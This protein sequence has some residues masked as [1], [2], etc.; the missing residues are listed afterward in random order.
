MLMKNQSTP[1][2]AALCLLFVSFSGIALG[3]TLQYWNPSGTGGDGIWGTGPGDKNWNLVPGALVGNTAWDDGIDDVAVFQDMIGGTVTVFDTVQTAGISQNGSNYTVNAGIIVLVPDS[4]SNAPF[5]HVQGGMLTMDAQL[6]GNAGLLKTGEGTLLLSAANPYTG[7]T[8]IQG[9][10]V[11]LTGSLA[12]SSLSI[13]SGASLLNQNGG[14]SSATSLTNVGSLTLNANDTITSYISNGGTLTNGPGTLFTTSAEINDGSTLAGLLNAST[15]TSNGEVVISGTATAGSTSIES[16][17]L[18]LSGTLASNSVGIANGALL[19]NQSGGLSSGAVIT[20]AG[21]LVMNEN[22]S[23]S[24]YIS[25]GGTLTN[26]PRT[27]FVSDSFLNQGSSVGGLL[28]TQ[29][30][31]SNG[32]VLIN[33]TTTISNTAAVQSGTF[34]LTGTLS[35]PTLNIAAGATMIQNGTMGPGTPSLATTVLTNE[36]SLII[37]KSA[38]LKTYTSNG[39]LLDIQNDRMITQNVFLNDGSVTKGGSFSADLLTTTGAVRIENSALGAQAVVASGVLDLVGSIG[40]NDVQ[41]ASGA[42]LLNQNGGL[43]NTATVTNAGSLALFNSDQIATY[44]SNGGLLANSPGTLFSTSAILN[45]G[46]TVAGLLDT[47]TLASNGVVQVSGDISADSINLVTGTLTNTGTLGN[48][49]TLLNITGGATLVAGGTQ[50]YSLLTTSGTGP[51]AWVGDLANT[52]HIAPGGLGEIGTL[53]VAGD[54]SQSAGGMLTLDL[55]TVDN[56]LLDIT[57]SATFNGALVL[58]QL[59]ATPIAPFVPVTVVS[60]SS[61]AGNIT[62]LSENLDGV[63]FFNPGNGT[64]TRL[65]L[66]TGGGGSFFGA[67]RNQT[68]TWISLYDDVIEPGI[69]NITSGPGGYEITSGIADVGNP[70]LLWALS[71]SFTP[72]GL[73]AAL[74]NRLSP[75]VYAGFSDYAVQATRAHQRSALSAPPLE[76]REAPGSAKDGAKAAITTTAVPLDWEFFAAVDYFRAGTDNSRNQAD[77]DFHGMGVLGGARTRLREHTQLAVYL[78]ADSGT[79]DGDLIDADALGW[80]FGLIGEHLI[81]EKTRTHLTAGISYGSYLFDGTRGSAS[82]T[83]AGWTPGKVDF[84]DVDVDAF[85]LFIGVEGVAW[86]QDAL[87]LIPS[88]GLRYARTT[89]DSFHESTGGASGSPIALDVGRDRHESLLLELGLLA[90]VEVNPGLSLWGEGG[91]NIGLLGNARAISANFVKG[92]RAMRAEAGGLDDD[93]LYLGCGAIY[94]ITGDISAAIGYRADLRSGAESQQELRLSSSWR[95]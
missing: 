70:D 4:S 55:S 20:N 68:S 86:Q 39:G 67:T 26:G 90:Q 42:S 77:Y 75:E 73:N 57:G 25:N 80:T 27:L 60:A 58:N 29:T 69:I 72:D 19:V 40:A 66:P 45:T 50:S 71:A 65:E 76:P 23:V 2:P 49:S 48:G 61:Y 85:D 79:I 31:V 43:R 35:T 88:A 24:R 21:S 30:L 56:D 12:S 47:G 81:H 51:G 17:R 93:S 95:F 84:D 82:A 1:R 59:G 34:T 46:S 78:G 32:V 37:Q 91:L 5:V 13:S 16:G 22:D 28:N 3:Q 89:M 11:N 87:T 36:G 7:L 53:A 18:T 83:G 94:Q 54:F 62:S 92:S 64:V 63:V 74:L 10:T 15:L 9:G 52:A 33:G 6:A 44:T 8:A 14:F 38:V 41:I